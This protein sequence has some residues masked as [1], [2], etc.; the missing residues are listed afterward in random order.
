MVSW[1]SSLTHDMSKPEIVSGDASFRKF[2]RTKR[3]ILMDAPPKTEKNSEFVLYS[4]ILRNAG[5][6]APEI[7]EANY[8]FGFLLVEDLGNQTLANSLTNINKSKLY[9][10]AIDNLTKFLKVDSS[11][12]PLYDKSFIERENSICTE[13]CFNK[14]LRVKFSA[15]EMKI[16]NSAEALMIENDLV[17]PQIAMHRDYHSRNIM[18]MGDELAIVDFQDMVKGPLTYDLVSLLRDC[19]YELSSREMEEYLNY[20]YQKYSENFDN[21]TYA[22]FVRYFDLTGLQRHYKCL[23][24]FNRLAIR[25]G[26]KKYLNDLPLVKKYIV[27][28]ANRYEE[29]K[30]FANL[31]D[32]IVKL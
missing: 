3:G 26:K 2:Y 19:Y 27:D 14:A 25:D 12:L 24:I 6:H 16:I 17:Q 15:E 5:L 29:L 23:G 32:N 4:N 11:S 20:A 31:I 22:E 9:R 10:S 13:W 1:Y 8:E 7:Y 21:I 18:C 30:D 28:V